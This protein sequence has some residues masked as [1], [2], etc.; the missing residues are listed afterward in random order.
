MLEE[1]APLKQRWFELYPHY[2]DVR[3]DMLSTVVHWEW[4]NGPRYAT[5]DYY[6]WQARRG[7]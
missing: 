6:L 3:D 4:A 7:E 2:S 5:L 1:I